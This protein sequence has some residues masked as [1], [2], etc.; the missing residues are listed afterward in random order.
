VRKLSRIQTFRLAFAAVLALGAGVLIRDRLDRAEAFALEQVRLEAYESNRHMHLVFEMARTILDRIADHINVS[1]DGSL[2]FH[3]RLDEVLDQTTGGT[4]IARG[5]ILQDRNGRIVAAGNPRTGVGLTLATLDFFQNLLKPDARPYEIGA[6]FDSTILGTIVIPVAKAIRDFDGT[7]VGVISVAVPIAVIQAALAPTIQTPDAR[8]RLWRTDGMLLANSLGDTTQ[9]GAFHPSMPLFAA[10]NGDGGGVFVAQATQDGEVHLAAW[11]D[12]LIY[13][14]FISTGAHR[15]TLLAR[16]YAETAAIGA[17]TLGLLV[18][19]LLVAILVDSERARTAAALAEKAHALAIKNMF[20]ANMSHEFRTPL[21]AISGYLQMLKLGLYG[22]LADRQTAAIGSVALAGEHLVNLTETLLDLSRIEA[23][24]LPIARKPENVAQIVGEA[25]ALVAPQAGN[26]NI[27]LAIDTSPTGLAILGDRLRARQIL[28]NLLS[29]AIRNGRDGGTVE[30]HIEAANSGS[31][32]V[33]VL[34]DG[35]GFGTAPFDRLFQPFAERDAH[36][37]NSGGVGL[38]L[39]LARGL[40][41]AQ[42][43]D[44]TLSNRPEGGA[45]ATLELPKAA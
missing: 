13:P 19:L 34:D 28:A 10:K 8:S 43:G 39:P 16:D 6:P 20:L 22:P 35:P 7:T 4:S 40:A 14:F 30:I 37:A 17:A 32:R 44:V 21:N 38:G 45:A 2:A 23:G 11:N 15:A 1:V 5:A 12:N 36:V 41:R 3:A 9:I 33:S 27:Q 42:G 18:L 29:N 24:N 26:K 25:V 31:V